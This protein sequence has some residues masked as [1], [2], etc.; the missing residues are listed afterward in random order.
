MIA[1]A[2]LRSLN[3]PGRQERLLG[4]EHV[5]DEQVEREA[6]DH[7]LDD[8]LA[9]AEPVEFLAA[10]QQ[11]LEGAGGE[12]Q[13][14]EAI[15]GE[16]ELRP[17]RRLA[18]EQ[19]DAD[20][21]EDAER[22]VDVE[23]PAP[24]V[25]IGQ[26]A[27][28]GRADHRSHR[29]AHGE[30]RH[31]LRAARERIDVE[32]RR[33]R[34][35]RQCRAEHALQQAEAHQLFQRLRRTAQHGGGGEADDADDEQPLAAEADRHPADRRCHDGGGDHIGGEHPGD[36]VVRRRHAALHVWQRDVGDGGV[37]RLHEHRQHRGGGDQAAVGD[38]GCF[39]HFPGRS[40][41]A[42]GLCACPTPCATRG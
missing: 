32:H 36:L 20:Q 13:H 38:A 34:Q 14:G 4:G 15:P 12:P 3:R 17:R 23:H 9:R 35:R 10:V 41:Q 22:Q 7:R 33:L 27:A 31:R 18:H 26:I 37:Q 39:G 29:D 1:E 16:P 40:Q 19:H 25:E 6:R 5:H 42:G 24:G 8:D 30:D 2:K 11:H 28:E 21:G